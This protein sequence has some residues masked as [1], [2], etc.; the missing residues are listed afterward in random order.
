MRLTRILLTLLVV[1]VVGCASGPE[2]KDIGSGISPI[3]PGKGRIYVYRPQL[4]FL[5]VGAVTLNG[6]EV[7][8]PAAGG[9]IF[10]DREP[11]EY[12]VLV[13][14]VTDESATFE[15]EAEKEVY[16]RITVDAG[17]YFLYTISP[18]ITDRATAVE[19]MQK[20]NYVEHVNSQQ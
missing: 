2:Y 15:L 1:L 4:S 20:L 6:E 3:E 11:G 10:V 9:F 17:G 13:D 5:Y 18:Q 12:V 7:R 19:E 8:V 16:I 14:A